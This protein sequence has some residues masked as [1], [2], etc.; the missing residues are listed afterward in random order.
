[1]LKPRT[2]AI[3]LLVA[4]VVL[5]GRLFFNAPLPPLTMGGETVVHQLFGRWDLRNTIIATW[6]S[7]GVILLVVWL[8]TRKQEMVP[9]GWQNL[10][11]GVIEA[12]LSLVE[13]VAG[14]TWGRRFF[15]VVATI[16]IFVL[17]TNYFGLIPL[18][19]NLGKVEPASEVILRAFKGHEESHARLERVLHEAEEQH[20]PALFAAAVQ[21]EAGKAGVN[22]DKVKLFLLDKAGPVTL[23]PVGNMEK[24][25]TA[26]RY[27]QQLKEGSFPEGK[28][29]GLL[30]PYIRSTNTDL[31][32]TLA[33]A[34]VAMVMVEV[35]GIRAHGLLGYGSRFFNLKALLQGKVIDFMVGGLETISEFARLISFTFRLFGNIFAGLVLVLVATFL[36]PFLGGVIPYGLELFVGF[37]QALVFAMLTLVFAAIAVQKHEGGEEGAAGHEA[38]G[39]EGR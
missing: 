29:A 1:M 9:R 4:A 7:M 13:S 34:L 26:A 25:T 33:I 32:S 37:I 36:L 20:Q 38:S 2:L 17:M 19:E 12:A 22:L 14:K 24:E 16:F 27:A 23:V 18:W 39:S 6:A 28:V 8:A 15:P 11:E 21:E 31:N 3:L 30:V 10:F 5:I 35:W